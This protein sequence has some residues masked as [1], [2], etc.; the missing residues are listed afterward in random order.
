MKTITAAI[1]MA[2]VSSVAVAA[3]AVY[4]APQAPI[5]NDAAPFSWTGFNV[6]V[7]EDL[8]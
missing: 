1:A 2:L 3:D 7:L 6:G 4:E 8:R 5:A